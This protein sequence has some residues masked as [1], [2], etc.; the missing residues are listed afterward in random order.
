[1]LN[2]LISILGLTMLN[3]IVCF[4]IINF[5]FS[6]CKQMY[7]LVNLNFFSESFY[8]LIHKFCSSYNLQ[9]S[10]TYTELT[11]LNRPFQSFSLLRSP[12]LLVSIKTQYLIIFL[13][14]FLCFSGSF[15]LVRE[16]QQAQVMQIE[17]LTSAIFLN[18]ILILFLVRIYTLQS[19]S[20]LRFST[21][22]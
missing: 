8:N 9:K 14:Q 5:C 2:I 10:A 19:F 7:Y 21:M 3:E 16:P 6:V 15:G 12:V 20:L 4:S 13:Y 17:I 11:S 18:S 22:E 1:M